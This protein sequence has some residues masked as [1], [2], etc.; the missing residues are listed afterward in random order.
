MALEGEE[1][2][3]FSAL[4]QLRESASSNPDD[5]DVRFNLGVV[6]WEKGERRPELRHE[7]VEHFMIAAKLNPQ[8]AATFRYLGHYYARVSPEPQRALKCYQRAV[9]LNPDDSDAGEA[10]CDLLD[11]GGQ[12]NLMIAVCREASE[13]SARAFWAFR[14]LGYLQAHHKN[15]AEAIQSLQQAIR[16]FPTSADLWETLGLAYGRM[17]MFTAALKSYGRAVELDDSRIFALVESGNISLMLGS[18][19]KGIE[20]FQ[21]AL[22]ISPHNVSANYGL[23]SAFLGLAKECVNSGAFRWGASLLEEATEVSTHVTSLAGNFS[24]SWKLHGDIQLMYARCNPWTEEAR[25]GQVDEISFKSSVS[26]WKR[27]CFIAS[28]NAGRSYQRAL[29]LAPWLA[30]A[31]IDVA[32]AADVSLSFKESAK[33]DWSV[34]PIAEKMCFGGILL[35][36]YNDEFWVA[37]ACLS[38]NAALKQHALVRGLQLDVSLAVAWAYLGKL[39]RL[40]GEKK[41]AQQAFD[42]AR[43]IEPSLALPWAG[44]SA[45]ADVRKFE[46]NEAYECCL[47]AVQISPVADFQIGLAK[48]ALHSS[49]LSSSE[50]FAA[51]QQALLHIPH[52]PEAHNLNGLV[53]ESRSDYQGAVASYR[54][55]RYAL[56]Y[57]AD[58]TSESHSDD[59]SIN[60]ARSLCMAGNASE[61]VEECEHLRQKGQLDTV[62]LHIYA[63]GLWRLGKNDMALSATRSLA[64]SILSMEENLAAAS[65]SFICR[66]LY[67]IS[68]QESAITSILKMP[69]Q[70]FSSSKISFIVSAIH[71]LDPNNQLEAVVSSSRSFVTSRE[72][73]ISMHMLI[74]VGKLLKSGNENSL[75]IQKGVDHLRKAVH[76]FPNSSVLRNLLGYLLLSSKERGYLCPATRCSS[77]DLSDYQKDDGLKSA[78]EI[79]GAGNVAC[80]AIGSPNQ[81][82]PLP[83]CR[84]QCYS[85]SG[86]IQVLQKYLHQEPWNFNARYLLAVNCLQKTRAE[87]FP[88]HGCHVVERL[89]AVALSD[90]NFSIKDVSRQY[91]NFQLLLCAAEVNLQQGNNTECFRLVRS[92]LSTSLHSNHLFFAHLLL[93]RAYASEEDFVN[94][95]K[96]YKYC[97]ELGTYSHIGWICLKFIESRYGLQDDSTV[98]ALKFED[99]SKDL[100]MSW[101][102]WTALF[103]F[104]QGLISISLGDFVAAEE[105]FSQ[106]CCV[107]DDESCFFLCHGAICMELARQKCESHYIT[108]AIRSLKKAKD[109][110]ADPLPLVSLLLGQ[111]EASLGS[112]EKWLV[113]LRDEWFSWP[114][115][116]R[117]AE[118][119]FQMHLLSRESSHGDSTMRWIL[120]AIHMNPS[121]SRYWKF[122]LK[123]CD[124]SLI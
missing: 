64:S 91:Q 56:K 53:C 85:G 77:L 117:S 7:A 103:S 83:T 106:A 114:P 86:A 46:Q 16:G 27:T 28:R 63:L 89:T 61:A 98:L 124:D 78:Y 13:K 17:G 102:I 110:S 49:C 90:Q 26:A 52:Y 112:K 9:A 104:V 35:E 51:I 81:K 68:G 118:L 108:R 30:N 97:L 94:L 67:N 3:D 36:G 58:E 34:W 62:G 87:K 70:L 88:Q 15:W 6:L 99:C 100:K 111:A 122:L 44:M 80:Y 18:F 71:V 84:R 29:H 32:I 33:D 24:C 43:S 2:C 55:A 37:L 21:Q 76:M 12:D 50:V 5:A 23:A 101:N 48:L 72:D 38:S 20:Q 93:C 14:R 19:R 96:E 74:T 31:Y 105:F 66:M 40:E 79:V 45:D 57:F 73:I 95:H 54:L 42:R 60:L 119:L 69:K 123:E 11:E 82:F 65:I 47:R 92:A 41:L 121:C 113:N 116:N 39:Y 109:T 75:G 115:E 120:R 22:I 25:P 4:K 8:N 107:P 10:I 1:E 59:I